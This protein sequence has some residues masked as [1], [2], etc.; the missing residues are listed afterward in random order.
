MMNDILFRTSINEHATRWN[1][2]GMSTL[3]LMLT[4]A[5]GAIILAAGLFTLWRERTKG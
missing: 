1:A 3:D 4:L 5:V 2:R